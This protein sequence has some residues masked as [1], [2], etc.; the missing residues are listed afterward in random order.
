MKSIVGICNDMDAG[1]SIPMVL[2]MIGNMRDFIEG[3]HV[4]IKPND[5]WA[6][7]QDRTGCTQPD[8]LEAVIRCVK[9]SD[10]KKIT[11]TG[12][13]GAA[14]TGD[15]FRIVGLDKVID[16]ESVEF[17]DHNRPPFA[18]VELDYGP[19]KSIKV[20][21]NVLEYECLI[22]LAQH[23]VHDAAVVTLTMK[24]VGM[25]FPAADYYGHSRETMLHPH[26]FFDDLHGFIAGVC[27]R[28]PITV[29]IIAGHPA[30][31]GSGP[32][33][34]ATFE[35]GLT[36]A[37][38]DSVACDA[39]GAR[40][41]GYTHVDQVERAGSLRLGQSSLEN[42]QVTGLPLREAEELFRQRAGKVLPQFA[43]AR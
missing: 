22:S 35:S 10:P 27:K 26:N 37:S 17:V 12:G 18:D 38:T 41:L 8:T 13:S 20:N 30:M 36:I 16:K 28:F 43:G 31:V 34:G 2:G 6:S 40:L 39:I 9:Q 33:G 7:P 19:Q 3:K 42:I 4:A 25:S 14:E 32:I 5:T 23:K 21:C 11:V 29:G 15:V 1:N 24:N